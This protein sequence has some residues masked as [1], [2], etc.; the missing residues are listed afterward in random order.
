MSTNHC[1][2]TA[3]PVVADVPSVLFDVNVDA[4]G[5]EP[6]LFSV[7]T[8]GLLHLHELGRL[9]RQPGRFKFRAGALAFLRHKAAASHAGG[10]ALPPA[11]RLDIMRHTGVG[12]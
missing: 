4:T 6:G 3:F 11:L 1:R 5:G 8:H 7:C 2:H 9:T 12:V 10:L